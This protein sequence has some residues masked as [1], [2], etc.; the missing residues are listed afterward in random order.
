MA[1][2]KQHELAVEPIQDAAA[3]FDQMADEDLLRFLRSLPVIATNDDEPF[4]LE[5]LTYEALLQP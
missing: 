4:T 1:N 5:D 2:N 3:F